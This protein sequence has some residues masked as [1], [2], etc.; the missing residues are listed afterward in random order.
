MRLF[1][2]NGLTI[3]LVLTSLLTIGGMLA[4]GWAVYNE[5]LAQHQ[6]TL[7]TL[8]SYAKSGHFLSALFENWESE[9]LQMSAYVMLTAFLFQRGS[10]ESKD[11]DKVT[12]QDEDSAQ[13]ADDAEA[14][15]P[16]KAGGFIRTL[17]SYSLG[18]ALFF[19]FIVSFVLHLKYSADAGAL[20]AAMHGEPETSLFAHLGSVE[21]WFE[22]FQNWQSEFLSTAVLVVLSIFLRFRGSPESK[23]V[24]APHSETGG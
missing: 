21:F 14:P 9:F 20:E 15:W 16:V 8:F 6:A 11:P 22:S 23:P 24:A 13:R 10:A 5:E 17:Y 2:D 7:L 3:V 18:L 19:L 12:S 1:R 4:T